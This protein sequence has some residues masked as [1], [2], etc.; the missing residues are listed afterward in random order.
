MNY[1]KS[2]NLEK[3]LHEILVYTP[4]DTILKMDNN[5]EIKINESL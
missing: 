1:I 5:D 4:T 3:L 2:R